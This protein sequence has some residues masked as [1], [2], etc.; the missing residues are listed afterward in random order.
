MRAVLAWL[1]R[2][3]TTLLAAGVFTGLLLPDAA[4]LLRP[5]LTPAVWGLLLLALLRIDWTEVLRQARRPGPALLIVVWLLIACP[6][7]MAG[8]VAVLA[9]PPGLATALVL[10]A[11][12]PPIISAPAIA[13]LLG[14]DGALALL[15]M[16]VA[17]LAA[18]LL[19]PVT[20]VALFGLGLQ[21]SI[22]D[23]MLSLLAFIGTAVAVA[24]VLRHGLGPSRLRRA[25][26]GLDVAAV[27][28]LLT[29]AI[30]IMDG[31]ADRLLADPAWVLTVAAAAIAV[32]LALQGAGGLAFAWLDR[33]RAVTTAFISG[34]RNMAVVLAVLPAGGH[35]DVFLYFAMAQIPIY[36]LPALLAPL[37]RRVVAGH[38]AGRP[39]GRVA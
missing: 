7:L 2:R 14:L 24:T 4:A 34:N 9:P 15:V 32:N 8:V 36:V 3:A 35:A 16:V 33:R 39:P 10:V 30:A 38:A 1:A 21:L 6:A 13:V 18:P 37:Y 12:V 31:V 17:T 20:G 29:F 23:L 19:L 27:L 26:T 22:A 5:L 25:A 28:L 11:A